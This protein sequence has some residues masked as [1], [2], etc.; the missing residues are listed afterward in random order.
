MTSST[1]NW[2]QIGSKDYTFNKE[3]KTQSNA[4]GACCLD[5]GKL[6]EPKDENN[7]HEVM[8]HA[9]GFGDIWLGIND[10]LVEGQFVYESDNTP[11]DWSKWVS[12]ESTE[13]NMED[14]VSADTNSYGW[15]DQSCDN[16][17]NYYVCER[18]GQGKLYKLGLIQTLSVIE[19]FY[20]TLHQF[21][22]HQSPTL[23]LLLQFQFP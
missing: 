6:Y 17:T 16:I 18:N 19:F 10:K 5:G 4:K 20:F 11:I 3:K 13:A 7:F 14:C 22:E 1:R 21:Q 8:S 12:G 15:Y 2:I 23:V 9:R